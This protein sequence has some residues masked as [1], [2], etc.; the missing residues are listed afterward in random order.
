MPRVLCLTPPP[1][2]HKPKTSI[3]GKCPNRVTCIR[4]A[5]SSFCRGRPGLSQHGPLPAHPPQVVG[6]V[7]HAGTWV[8]SRTC[9]P[10]YTGPAAAR[11]QADRFGC[12]LLLADRA[13]TRWSFIA[14]HL[15][16]RQP[17]RCLQDASS[18]PASAGINRLVYIFP[19]FL[20][21]RTGGR[22]TRQLSENAAKGAS[23]HIISILPSHKLWP[24]QSG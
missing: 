2:N 23:S 6:A 14:L 22:N 8:S 24:H 18:R 16:P 9:T 21:V 4:P 17:T 15:R 19:A 20:I 7:V 11:R 3:L 13:S 12:V 1:K 10:R 5:T